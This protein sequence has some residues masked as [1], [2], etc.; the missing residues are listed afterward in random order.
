MSA[1]FFV[2]AAVTLAGAICAMSLRNLV[3]CGLCLALTF[4]GLAAIYLQL[5][6][7]FVGLAQI[8]VYVGAVAILIVFT[9][10]LTRNSE[11]NISP[12]S[13]SWAVGVII[14]IIVCASLVL[15]MLK[16]PSLQRTP[17]LTP[18]ATVQRIGEKLMTVYVIP[19]EAIALVLT[20]A[21]LGAVVIAM[22]DEPVTRDATGG[23][24]S[25]LN[26]E[27]AGVRG[28][29]VERGQQREGAGRHHPSPL[30]PLPVER[31]GEPD[32]AGGSNTTGAKESR[33]S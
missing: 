28:G 27:K 30:T 33:T 2:L 9:I 7:E 6:A 12:V 18:T 4:A 31:R 20:A 24:P 1:A 25:P 19:L 32:V 16:S 22:R 29:T 11:V 21:L 15:P 13:R 8:L 5:T 3:H 14:A 23:S 26:G 17:T 10:L